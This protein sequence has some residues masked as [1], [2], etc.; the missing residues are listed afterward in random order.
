MCQGL[1]SRSGTVSTLLGLKSSNLFERLTRFV[2]PFR[3]SG[4]VVQGGERL[5][6][7]LMACRFELLVFLQEANLPH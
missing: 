6:S 2:C 1:C 3:K 4:K 5:R 7:K